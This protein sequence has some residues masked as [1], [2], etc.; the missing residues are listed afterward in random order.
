MS[1]LIKSAIPI[2]EKGMLLN[3]DEIRL[4][5]DVLNYDFFTKMNL[6]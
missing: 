3:V 2:D 1:V 6:I 5:M 4:K